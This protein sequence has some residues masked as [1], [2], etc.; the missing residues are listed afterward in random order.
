[1]SF[2]YISI[3]FQAGFN[4]VFKMISRGFYWVSNGFQGGSKQVGFDLF[5]TGFNQVYT[6]WQV[7]FKQVLGSF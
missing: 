3:G 7:D 6:G 1:M 4:Q 2:K 5:Q